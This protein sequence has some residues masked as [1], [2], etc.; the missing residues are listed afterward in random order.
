MKLKLIGIA[1]LALQLGACS[2][3]VNGTNQ[4]IAFTTGSVSG[5]DCALTG[6]SNHAVN[7]AFQTPAEVKVPRS[8]KAL[9]LSC[10]KAGYKTAEALID[11]KV[12]ETTGGNV[13]IGGFI[14]AGVDAITGALYRYPDTVDLPLTMGSGMATD[15][16]IAK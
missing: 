10:A 4:T 2:T 16:P 14:G 11:G 7:E 8:G 9:N 6:G 3:V 13:L 12:E 5:A 15:E 1:A